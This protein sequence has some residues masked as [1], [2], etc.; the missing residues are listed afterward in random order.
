M[1]SLIHTLN[2]MPVVLIYVN[3]QQAV[4]V[5]ISEARDISYRKT[6]Q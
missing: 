6:R 4:V 1:Q 2:W 3:K 5:C